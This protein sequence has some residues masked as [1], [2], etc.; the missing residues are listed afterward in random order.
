MTLATG[1][2]EGEISKH[3][4]VYSSD[5]NHSEIKLTVSGHIRIDFKLEPDGI[6]FRNH[7]RYM[8]LTREIRIQ[9]E[10]S[11]QIR[12]K[13]I[14]SSNKLIDGTVQSIQQDDKSFQIIKVQIKPGLPLG[15][16]NDVITVLTDSPK[17]PRISVQIHGEIIGNISVKP[18]RIDFGFFNKESLPPAK[19]IFLTMEKPG[20]RFEIQAIEDGTGV[21]IHK[22]LTV[23]EGTQ[24]QVCV[25]LLPEFNKKLINGS[26]FIHTNYPGEEKIRV[27]L[28][29]GLKP[30]AP[31]P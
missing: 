21:L 26:L 22:V 11:D 16:L 30:E 9:G 7:R 25:D 14:E 19:T 17:Y 8:E 10:R 24:Y 15:R 28:N 27:S 2:Y 3:V 4:V 12:I 6:M 1:N 5:P 29:G 18:E 23:K 13:D 31:F 20:D